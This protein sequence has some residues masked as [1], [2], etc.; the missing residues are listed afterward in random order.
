MCDITREGGYTHVY[1]IIHVIQAGL[2]MVI[3]KDLPNIDQQNKQTIWLFTKR[4]LSLEGREVK[5]SAHP[6]S[7]GKFKLVFN[8]QLKI[9]HRNPTEVKGIWSVV[10]Y[11]LSA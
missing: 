1:I 3:E 6:F 7:S 2:A 10:L 8:K 5:S 4:R 9:K 11:K